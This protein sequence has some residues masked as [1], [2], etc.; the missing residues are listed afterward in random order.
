M[1]AYEIQLLYV[2]RDKIR[3]KIYFETNFCQEKNLLE[4]KLSW[5]LSQTEFCLGRCL[6]FPVHFSELSWTN[7]CLSSLSGMYI[8]Q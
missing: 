8:P 2:I 3:D 5:I 1:I 4:K 7:Q 6:R